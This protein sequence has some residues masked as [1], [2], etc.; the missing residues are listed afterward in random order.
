M[1]KGSIEEG[2]AADITIININEEQVIDVNKFKSK[3]KNSPFHG[4]K[5][6]GVV[7]HTIVNGKIVVREKVLL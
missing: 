1:N 7:Y 5:L 4:F 3:S 6:K 2:R